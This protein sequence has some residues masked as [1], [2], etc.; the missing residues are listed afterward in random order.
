MVMVLSIQIIFLSIFP[1]FVNTR[2]TFFSNLC[3][4]D[5]NLLDNTNST[6]TQTLPVRN[7]SLKL[8]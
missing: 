7:T 5:C 2:S 4:L 3:S 1:L 6:L 8:N